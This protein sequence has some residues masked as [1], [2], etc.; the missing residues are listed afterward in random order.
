MIEDPLGGAAAFSFVYPGI[1]QI[2]GIA[3]QLKL[4]F[5]LCGIVAKDRAEVSLALFLNLFWNYR[6]LSTSR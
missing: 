4:P 3:K 6:H 5:H 1:A 2:A